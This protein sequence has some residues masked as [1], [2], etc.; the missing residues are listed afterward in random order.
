MFKELDPLL[1][2]QLRLAVISLL[3]GVE[4]ADFVYIKDMTGATS[5]NLSIQ[6]DKLKEAGYIGIVKSFK[7]K[8]P[9]TTC[10]ITPE[11][12]DAFEAY[13]R[14]LQEYISRKEIKSTGANM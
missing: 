4:E 1:H 9:N 11:G 13:V 5:G 8:K 3:I 6:L 12:I 7:G 2:S 14:N 10:R